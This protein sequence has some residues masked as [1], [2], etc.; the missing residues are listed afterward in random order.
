MVAGRFQTY[1]IARLAIDRRHVSLLRKA[2][3]APPVTAAN[4]GELVSA[5]QGRNALRVGCF[6]GRLGGA[7]CG[8]ALW[9]LTCAFVL[10]LVLNLLS[11]LLRSSIFLFA[12]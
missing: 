7:V 10:F 3:S 1:A 2:H 9:R 5:P 8:I 6:T 4:K 11:F 12:R